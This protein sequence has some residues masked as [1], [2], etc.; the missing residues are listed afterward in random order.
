MPNKAFKIYYLSETA[1]TVEFGQQIA[2]EL[3]NAVNS[4]NL[5]L[6]QQPFPG[7]NTTVP[8]YSTLTVFYDP[9]IVI[10]S[11]LPGAGCFAKVSGYLDDLKFQKKTAKPAGGDIITIPVCYGGSFGPDL[12]EVADSHHISIAEV[13]KLHNAATYKVYMI[14]FVPGF[15]YLG[16]MDERLATPRK[17]APR[18]LVPAGAVGIAGQQTGVYPLDTPGGWQI[19]GQTPLKMFDRD[20]R[21]PSLLKAGDMVVFK[22]ID[23]Q[24]FNELLAG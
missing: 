20:R 21:Q 8:A 14:G 23:I 19:I 1:V 7:F 4:L 15:A 2:E 9:V 24:E 17:A 13:I 3:L 6:H 22:A 18:K 10:K 11:D 5:L 16:G 12:E